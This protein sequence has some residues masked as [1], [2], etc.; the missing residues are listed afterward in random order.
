M[1]IFHFI[2]HG[3]EDLSFPDDGFWDTQQVAKDSAVSLGN[4][5]FEEE[6]LMADAAEAIEATINEST[7]LEETMF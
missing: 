6:L 7:F 5:S 2:G 1:N 4:I 3:S